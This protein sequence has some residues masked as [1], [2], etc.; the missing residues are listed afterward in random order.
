MTTRIVIFQNGA[1]LGFGG[2]GVL[3][4]MDKPDGHAHR[5]YLTTK[6]TKDTKSEGLPPNSLLEQRYIKI[7]QECQPEI[8]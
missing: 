6:D 4:G 5:A 8:R 1:S 7:D 2:G 3:G